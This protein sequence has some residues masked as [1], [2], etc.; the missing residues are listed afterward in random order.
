MKVKEKG[1]IRNLIYESLKHCTLFDTFGVVNRRKCRQ[2]LRLRI[3][4]IFRESV[5]FLR[6]AYN[7]LER[8]IISAVDL[9]V[10]S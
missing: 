3:F 4:Y 1:C 6:N 5:M 10:I 7:P 2:L 9:C 8:L